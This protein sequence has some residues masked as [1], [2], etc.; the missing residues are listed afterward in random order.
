MT[1][2]AAL[3]IAIVIVIIIL[4]AALAAVYGYMRR[5][6]LK[7][8]RGQRIVFAM[9]EERARET[10]KPLVVVGDPAPPKTYNARFGA[11]YGG[12]DYCI[13]INGCESCIGT[14]TKRVKARV[15]D[16]L[17]VMQ[18]NSAV[19]F[20]SEV[21]PYLPEK[22]VAGVIAQMMR[23]SGGD[24][25]CCHSNI[26]DLHRYASTGE[27]Q[28]PDPFEVWRT[29]NFGVMM[30]V[31]YAFPPFHDFKAVEFDGKKFD[32]ERNETYHMSKKPP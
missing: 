26:I 32:R 29:R 8:L 30:R 3:S 2:T 6:G 16:A 17:R 22:E 21:L 27:V 19:I 25:F 24:V 9:A 15:Q 10:G 4:V 13:D 18:D 14:P 12:G 5:R 11:G 23:V 7:K 1:R 31:Y 20:E 28:D